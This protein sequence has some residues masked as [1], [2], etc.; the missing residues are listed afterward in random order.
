MPLSPDTIEAV[1]LDYVAR[2]FSID[3]IAERHGLT[4]HEVQDLRR[5]HEWPP[6]RP[7]K[8]AAIAAARAGVSSSTR[9]PAAKVRTPVAVLQK[10]RLIERLYGAITSKLEQMEISMTRDD[11]AN[12]ADS[13]R[14]TRALGHLVKN[15]EKVQSLETDLTRDAGAAGGKLGA[16][17]A[18]RQGAISA[19]DAERKRG[20]LAERIRK[21]RERFDGSVGGGS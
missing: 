19:D 13:E 11:A 20:A 15:F 17:G 10:R 7:D 2:E 21:V 12:P 5:L 3:R 4:R 16:G 9:A 6:R 8:V 1:R 18:A 14:E